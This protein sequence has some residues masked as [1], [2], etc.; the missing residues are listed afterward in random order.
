MRFLLSL[1]L[2]ST[3][4]GCGSDDYVDQDLDPQLLSIVREFEADAV[5]CDIKI[6][7]A[8]LKKITYVDEFVVDDGAEISDLPE[9]TI[10]LALNYKADIITAGVKTG[11]YYWEE[12]QIKNI[13]R[14]YCPISRKALVYHEL[15]HASLKLGHDP[16][17]QHII[18]AMLNTANCQHW[19]DNWDRELNHFFGKQC[20]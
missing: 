4:C 12:I 8:N 20:K 7:N 11:I 14:S 5:A 2:L 17:P 18:S 10:G 3:V 6:T 16:D 19:E 15:G 13:A 1:I 9:K